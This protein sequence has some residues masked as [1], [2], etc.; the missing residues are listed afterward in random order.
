MRQAF[1]RALA[2]P[3]VDE[4]TKELFATGRRLLP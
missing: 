1:D 3:G 2:Q 4:A